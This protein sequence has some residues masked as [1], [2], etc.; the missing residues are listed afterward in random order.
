MPLKG[1]LAR[2]MRHQQAAAAVAAQPP[3]PGDPGRPG[4]AGHRSAYHKHQ[5][6][7]A[8]QRVIARRALTR[9][10]SWWTGSPGF[11]LKSPVRGISPRGEGAWHIRATWA[12]MP[13][14]PVTTARTGRGR[15]GS[16]AAGGIGRT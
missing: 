5:G 9:L 2:T 6:P 11:E 8:N 12:R 14:W 1:R 16:P 10:N 4:P 3:A 7:F 13:G 15:I